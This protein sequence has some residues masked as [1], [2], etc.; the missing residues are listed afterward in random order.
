MAAKDKVPQAAKDEVNRVANLA[1][2][3]ARSGA[4]FYPI[5]V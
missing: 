5:K 1:S 3:A 2:D 4:Y